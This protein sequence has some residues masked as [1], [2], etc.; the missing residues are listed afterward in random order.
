MLAHDRLTT[1]TG[2]YRIFKQAKKE[3]AEEMNAD[4]SRPP[5]EI[6]TIPDVC[7]TSVFERGREV[8]FAHPKRLRDHASS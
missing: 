7:C 1:R 8:V 4:K 5:E 6:G 2:W 3:A